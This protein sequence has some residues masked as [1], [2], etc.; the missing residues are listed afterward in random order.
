MKNLLNW[1][2]ATV[3][4]IN[5]QLNKLAYRKRNEDRTMNESKT[6]FLPFTYFPF[7]SKQR[8]GLPFLLC[9]TILAVAVSIANYLSFRGQALPPSL[10]V[11]VECSP[12]AKDQKSYCDIDEDY[13]FHSVIWFI[14]DGWPWYKANETIAQFSDHYVPFTTAVYGTRWSHTVYTTWFTGLPSTNLLATPIKGDQLFEATER[15]GGSRCSLKDESVGTF[16]RNVSKFSWKYMGP[17]WAPAALL[18][19]KEKLTKVGFSEV[20]F[21]EEVYNDRVYDKLKSEKVFNKTLYDSAKTGQSIVIHSGIFDK[22]GHR[23][24]RDPRME[25]ESLNLK[26]FFGGPVLKQFMDSHPNYL[27]I[28]SADHG[29]SMPKEGIFHGNA[30]AGSTGNVGW[31]A[32]YNSKFTSTPVRE[33]DAVDVLP[34]ITKYLKNVDIPFFSTGQVQNNYGEGERGMT[35]QV[36]ALKQNLVQFS[37]VTRYRG[38]KIDEENIE[39]LITEENVPLDEIQREVRTLK[40]RLDMAQNPIHVFWM[41]IFTSGA[42]LSLLFWMTRNQ[43]V[44]RTLFLSVPSLLLI[45]FTYYK[46]KDFFLAGKFFLVWDACFS[47]LV[48]VFGRDRLPYLAVNELLILLSLGLSKYNFASGDDWFFVPF[49]SVP[50]SFY[51]FVH[52]HARNSKSSQQRDF[53]F[54]MN[55][56]CHGLLMIFLVTSGL[57]GLYFVGGFH[58]VVALLFAACLVCVWFSATRQN[59]SYLLLAATSYIMLIQRCHVAIPIL[60]L[61]FTLVVPHLLVPSRTITD[62][63][64]RNYGLQAAI[65]YSNNFIFWF[66]AASYGSLDFDVDLNAGAVGI[67]SWNLYPSYSGFVMAFSKIAII[68]LAALHVSTLINN[69]FLL[70]PSI[71]QLSLMALI[72]E[73]CIAIFVREQALDSALIMCVLFG[74][75]TLTTILYRLIRLRQ[76]SNSTLISLPTSL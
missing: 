65:L 44:I 24:K 46:F 71:L 17:E 50:V 19:G 66:Y 60:T 70:V 63:V 12:C 29:L 42:V 67:T 1:P 58:V 14:T 34:T 62:S 15:A 38:I 39:R 22:V 74:V 11:N 59:S 40:E 52:L 32:F 5:H 21:W 10:D 37:K 16:D 41:A 33:I 28:M 56:V 72:V 31:I 51:L 36:N 35:S 4:W 53:F 47:L 30:H 25:K 23:L 27:L 18:G 43:D 3:I 69:K 64:R 54:V 48:I 8:R 6:E 57:D 75:K 26:S 49:T 61:Q 55:A 45:S 20:T 9:F 76:S 73:W 2:S 13:Q 7:L 68:V